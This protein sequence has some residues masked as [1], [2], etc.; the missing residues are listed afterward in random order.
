MNPILVNSDLTVA[1]NPT[2]KIV[3]VVSVGLSQGSATGESSW[4]ISS[5]I[6]TDL[7][8]FALSGNKSKMILKEGQLKAVKAYSYTY[9]WMR[10]IPMV[11]GGYTYVI[12]HP[13]Y[14]TIGFN[15]SIINLKLKSEANNYSYQ[16]MSSLV[17][18]WTK[19]Y[20]LSAKSTISPGVFLMASPYSYN[21]KSGNSWNYNI[22]GLIGTGYTYQISKRF[23]LAL[24]YKLN[25]STAKGAPLLNFVMIGSRTI[26]L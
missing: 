5:M 24:D 6:F 19:P 23:V 26:L 12:P 25:A 22:A 10:G 14:G 9:A 20:K 15:T 8:S 1:Q 21:S 13:K 16:F 2:G 11:F 4:G 3:P 7:R 17:G 18:F